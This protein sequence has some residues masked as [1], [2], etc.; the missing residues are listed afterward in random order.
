MISICPT[1]VML[2]IRL[3]KKERISVLPVATLAIEIE[4]ESDVLLLD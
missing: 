4:V 3:T 1:T 2:D